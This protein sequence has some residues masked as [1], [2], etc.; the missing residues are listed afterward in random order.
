MSRA[1]TSDTIVLIPGLMN[2]GWV[3]RHQLGPLSRLGAVHVARTDG[4]ASLAEM[5]ARILDET[6][7]PLKVAGHSMGGRVAL[8][9]VAAAPRRVTRLALLD[10]GAHGAKP[11]EAEGRNALVELAR[12]EGM[13]AV[14]KAWLPDMLGDRARG[15]ARLVEGIGRMLERCAVMDFVAQQQALLER[16]DRMALL[17]DIACETLLITGAEDRWADPDQ[18]RWMASLIPGSRVEIV[19]GAGHM[20]PVEAPEALAG[21]LVAHFS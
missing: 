8:E 14:C 13:A 9:M 19:A 17:P 18:H 16:P 11:A 12:A 5:A 3:W 15:D 1:T 6:R 2:D 20:L 7:G 4:C 10:T 21:L